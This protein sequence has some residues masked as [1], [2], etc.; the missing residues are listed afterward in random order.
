MSG[1]RNPYEDERWWYGREPDPWGRDA[2]YFGPPLPP[3][4]A[5][6][7]ELRII[8]RALNS[9]ENV[10][11]AWGEGGGEDEDGEA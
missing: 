11:K 10:D 5:A 1:S 9:V 7:A 3:L 2:E 6:D 4:S 8:T